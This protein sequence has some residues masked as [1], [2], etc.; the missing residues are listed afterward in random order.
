MLTDMK[1]SHIDKTTKPM[2]AAE[3]DKKMGEIPGWSL[4]YPSLARDYKFKDFTG[5]MQFANRVAGLAEQEDHHPDLHISYNRVRLE[6]STH[7]IGGL[8]MNDFIMAA[9]INALQGE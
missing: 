1:C 6:L 8:S 3:A 4:E 7:S 9:K 5:A 2:P